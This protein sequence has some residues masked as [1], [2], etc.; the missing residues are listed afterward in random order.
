MKIKEIKELVKRREIGPIDVKREFSVLIPL[1]DIDGELHILYELRAKHMDRQPREISFPGGAVEDGETFEQAALRET[2][3]E[4]NISRDNI[5]IFSELDYLVSPSGMRINCFLGEI[6]N[7]EVDKL[8]PNIYEVDHVFTVP[9][10]YFLETEPDE[11]PVRFKRNLSADFPYNLI[12]NGRDYNWDKNVDNIYFYRY[13][14][15]NIWGFTARMT[16]NFI[17][18]L[19]NNHS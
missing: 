5:E 11:Y 4:L 16:K 6:S 18:I 12:P 7:I 13:R 1:I 19:K 9:L 10:K 3:E 14:E 17:D 15:Y 8:R 2:M